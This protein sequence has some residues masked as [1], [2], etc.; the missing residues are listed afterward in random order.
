M[1]QVMCKKKKEITPLTTTMTAVHDHNNLESE[2][3]DLN[4]SLPM[5]KWKLS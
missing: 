3:H 2:N 5:Q 4:G 1:D